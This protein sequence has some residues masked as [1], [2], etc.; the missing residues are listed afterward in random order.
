MAG[1]AEI[2]IVVPARPEAPQGL[3]GGSPELNV[4]GAHL[5][6]GD[7]VDDQNGRAPGLALVLTAHHDV[8]MALRGFLGAARV[9]AGV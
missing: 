7:A 4:D 9:P 8:E 1:G 5:K 3:I 6:G 2:E